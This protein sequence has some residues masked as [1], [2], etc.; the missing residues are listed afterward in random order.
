MTKLLTNH[1]DIRQWTEARSGSPALMEVPHG[2]H[3][4]TV[5]RLVFDQRLMNSG[6][7]DNADRPNALELAS[8]DDWFA[9]FE[10]QGLALQVDDEAPGLLDSD[11]E[12]VQRR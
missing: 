8:W 9:E 1:Q 4:H 12:F 10:S 2:S 6:E 3:S 7:N 11:H 5:L